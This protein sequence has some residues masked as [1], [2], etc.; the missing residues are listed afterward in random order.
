MVQV[1]TLR[2]L[3]VLHRGVR[4]QKA[5]CTCECKVCMRRMPGAHVNVRHVHLRV[6]EDPHASCVA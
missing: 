1:I 2:G 6:N 4:V 5:R 3:R